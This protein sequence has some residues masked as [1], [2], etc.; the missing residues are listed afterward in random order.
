MGGK[1][2]LVGICK[3]I[4]WDWRKQQRAVIMVIWSFGQNDFELSISSTIYK[5]LIFIY[6]E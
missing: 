1:W 6:S 2:D 5:Y 4:T 3:G